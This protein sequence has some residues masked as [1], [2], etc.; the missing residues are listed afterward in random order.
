M[1]LL[2]DTH[3]AIWILQDDPA[4]S[5]RARECYLD[6]ANEL[7]FSIASYWE[8][9]IKL[10]LGKLQLKGNW[11]TSFEEE[12]ARNEIQ[13]LGLHPRHIEGILE[14]PWHHRDPFDRLLIAQARAESMS[15][16]TADQSIRHY[17][18]DVIW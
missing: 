11:R 5:A 7:H 10:S 8:L 16:L 15:I 12:L 17:E 13:W 18:V 3:V 9:G 14:L 4:L 2:I 6:G 1:K